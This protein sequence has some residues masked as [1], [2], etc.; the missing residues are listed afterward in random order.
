[1]FAACIQVS[2]S[3]QAGDNELPVHPVVKNPLNGAYRFLQKE[4]K[5]ADNHCPSLH[6][7]QLRV[8]DKYGQT[9]MVLSL[10]QITE[11][12]GIIETQ[13]LFVNSG[14]ESSKSQSEDFVT[15]KIRSELV[16]DGFSTYNLSLQKLGL[17]APEE[18]RF[19]S[20]VKSVILTKSTQGK[21]LLVVSGYS[22]ANASDSASLESWKCQ[23]E[24][25]R[26][27]IY[28][29]YSSQGSSKPVLIP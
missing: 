26:S 23:Y 25:I 7:F 19:G 20:L 2:Q 8:K 12:Y 4:G 9:P 5:T 27:E 3:A 21:D 13:D 16:S 15:T 10:D 11:G 17:R 22:Q 1:M 18:I 29:H 28:T 14:T 24:K 6:Y